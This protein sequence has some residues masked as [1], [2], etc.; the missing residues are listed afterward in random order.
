MGYVVFPCVALFAW[1]IG[2]AIKCAVD[3]VR[4]YREAKADGDT[5]KKKGILLFLL[6]FA[7]RFAV[8]I[9]YI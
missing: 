1:I 7:I 4:A 8:L 5:S 3:C 2:G 9:A 6:I